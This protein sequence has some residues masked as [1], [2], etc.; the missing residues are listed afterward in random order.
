[1]WS[2]T[3]EWRLRDCSRRNLTGGAGGGVCG[4]WGVGPRAAAPD[5]RKGLGLEDKKTQVQVF[6]L[7]LIFVVH[8]SD[9]EIVFL[10]EN[11]KEM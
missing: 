1:M 7:K 8:F 3:Q 10:L 9:N 5:I 2:K 11:E 6:K 4:R